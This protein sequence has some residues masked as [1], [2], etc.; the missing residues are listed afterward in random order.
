[1]PGKQKRK[2]PGRLVPYHRRCLVQYIRILLQRIDGESESRMR[3]ATVSPA[4]PISNVPLRKRCENLFKLYI[5]TILLNVFFF[6]L[7]GAVSLRVVSYFVF[8]KYLLP[9]EARYT[10]ITVRIDKHDGQPAMI[11]SRRHITCVHGECTFYRVFSVFFFGNI[12]ANQLLRK[13]IEKWRE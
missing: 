10:N 3:G 1:M 6:A 4:Q 12:T 2:P 9:P 5:R 8:G 11:I 13:A 7:P